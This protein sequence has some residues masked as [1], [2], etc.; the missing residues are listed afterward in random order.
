MCQTKAEGGRR[1]NNSL[2]GFSNYP[3]VLKYD[4]KEDQFNINAE[5]LV[6]NGKYIMHLPTLLSRSNKNF[7][8]LPQS[9]QETIKNKANLWRAM[10]PRERWQ[11][12]ND[13]SLLE[14]PSKALETIYE[15]GWESNFPALQDI[16]NV[17]QSPDW[18][19]EGAVHIH[20]AEA[21][22]V[23][24]RN[25]L[26]E[27]LNKDETQLAVL[28]A[29]A[30]DFGKSTTTVIDENGNISSANHQM[31]GISISANFLE[32]INANAFLKKRIPRLVKEHMCHANDKVTTTAVSSLILRL[33]EDDVT[34]EQWARIAEADKGGR[35]SASTEGISRIWLD[36]KEAALSRMIS[37]PT[38]NAFFNGDILKKYGVPAGAIYRQIIQEFFKIQESENIYQEDERDAWL[39]NYLKTN[40]I[41]HSL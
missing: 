24:A 35:G 4:K 40:N 23:A 28:G 2:I 11:G 30:H 20:T 14:K 7:S 34:L 16:R 37:K 39:K 5:E 32:E 25:A 22:D 15:M 13:L 33:K 9:I 1:C 27:G 41:T 10:T 8:D 26:R 18:H 6:K 38:S 17:P 19:P 36:K 29:I 12:W 21:A 31:T 3:D